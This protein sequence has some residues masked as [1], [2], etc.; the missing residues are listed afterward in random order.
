MKVV[1]TG[2][3]GFV[4]LSITRKLMQLPDIHS[5]VLFDAEVPD[6]VAD[7]QPGWP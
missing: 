6:T 5:L 3:C 2:G 4:G 7:V 1:I